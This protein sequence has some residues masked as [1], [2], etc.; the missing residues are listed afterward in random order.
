MNPQFL[1]TD[2]EKPADQARQ[3]ASKSADELGRGLGDIKGYF[4]LYKREIIIIGA[5]GIIYYMIK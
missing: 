2:S 1:V 4:E 3:I 5:L